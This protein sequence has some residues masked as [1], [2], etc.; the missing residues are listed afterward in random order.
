[1]PYN[2][3]ISQFFDTFIS[4]EFKGYNFIAHYGKGIVFQPVL[5]EMLENKLKPENIS[6][7]NKI[8]YLKVNN[9]NTRFIDSI[10]FTMCALKHFPK[11]FG[12]EGKKGY[13]PHY[14]NTKGN[15]N[16]IGKMPDKSAYGY[17][18]MN[19]AQRLNVIPGMMH[20]RP[21]N[22]KKRCLNNA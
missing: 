19:E 10:N 11:T 5:R 17:S 3:V 12:I 18:K 1:M 13:F 6:S 21:L 2:S 9:L 4:P 14:F 16:Y 22:T 15:Q 20:L 7:R 8:N